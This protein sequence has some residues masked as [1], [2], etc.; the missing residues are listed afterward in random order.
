MKKAIINR[1]VRNLK[2]RTNNR[3]QIIYLDGK[4]V[5]VSGSGHPFYFSG[6]EFI[7]RNIGYIL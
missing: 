5:L 6:W 2:K 7:I 1:I 4:V 3:S